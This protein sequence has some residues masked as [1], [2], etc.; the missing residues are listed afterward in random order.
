MSISNNEST[1]YHNDMLN[2]TKSGSETLSEIGI[3]NN[4][5]TNSHN[6][7]LNQTKSGLETL[8]EIGKSSKIIFC[9]EYLS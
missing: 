9:L 8:G 7:V 2:Q 4:E 1:N 5:S 6:D 3:L